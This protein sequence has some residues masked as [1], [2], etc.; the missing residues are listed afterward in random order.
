MRVLPELVG[1][2]SH[3]GT[4]SW[5]TNGG[6]RKMIFLDKPENHYTGNLGVKRASMK[7][8]LYAKLKIKRKKLGLILLS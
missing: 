4:R 6:I 8:P 3:R 1:G 5:K 2:N 7:N